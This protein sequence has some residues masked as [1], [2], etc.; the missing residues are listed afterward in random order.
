MQE[1]VPLEHKATL[2]GESALVDGRGSGNAIRVELEVDVV[3]TKSG[4]NS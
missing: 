3:D 4:I 1:V 2:E